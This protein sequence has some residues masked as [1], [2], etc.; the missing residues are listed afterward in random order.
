MKKTV[1]MKTPT[2]VLISLALVLYIAAIL[3]AVFV[4]KPVAAALIGCGTLLF[5][6]G[7]IIGS[8]KKEENKQ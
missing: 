1:E 3:V 7:M 6:A 4:S 8:I 2:A 5:A